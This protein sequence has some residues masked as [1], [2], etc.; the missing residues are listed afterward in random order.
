MQ[1][2]ARV[3]EDNSPYV[4]PQRYSVV[5]AKCEVEVEAI[6]VAAVEAMALY[7]GMTV[8]DFLEQS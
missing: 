4:L 3:L 6:F 5:S 2:E 1:V 8:C 7:K